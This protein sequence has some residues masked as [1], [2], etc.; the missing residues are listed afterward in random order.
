MKVYAKDDTEM[1]GP[2][3]QAELLARRVGTPEQAEWLRLP[4]GESRT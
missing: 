1:L 2:A 4:E 3:L